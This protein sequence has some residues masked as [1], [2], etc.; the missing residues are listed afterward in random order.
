MANTKTAK[1]RI[2]TNERN[3]QRNIAVRSRMKT[4]IKEAE[5]ALA[6]KDKP[7]TEEA[8][9]AACSEID[10]AVKKGVIHARTG[11][12]KKS[13]LERKASAASK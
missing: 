3:R 4:H 13:S 2:I 11:A 8:V 10:R 9:K 1:K 7:K 5:T 6:G 12:R